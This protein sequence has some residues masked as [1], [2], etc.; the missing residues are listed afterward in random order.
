MCLNLKFDM[1]LCNDNFIQHKFFWINVLNKHKT[2]MSIC[3]K[4]MAYVPALLLNII[5][6]LKHNVRFIEV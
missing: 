6:K 1:I 5:L 3:S 4:Y 2:I